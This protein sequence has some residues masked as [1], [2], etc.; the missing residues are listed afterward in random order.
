MP[1]TPPLFSGKYAVLHRILYRGIR[2]NAEQIPLLKW[3]K[4]GSLPPNGGRGIP[5]T[6]PPPTRGGMIDFKGKEGRGYAEDPLLH[7][8]NIS[9]NR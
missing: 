5:D 2:R 3:G 1:D 7:D 6:P 9:T 8:R 4:G